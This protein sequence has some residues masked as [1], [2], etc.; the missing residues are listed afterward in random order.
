M[1]H[2]RGVLLVYNV[3]LYAA[4]IRVAR[5]AGVYPGV[6]GHGLLDH[7]ATRRLGPL[8]RYEA[9]AASR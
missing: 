4:R 5:L 3:H 6:A 1:M 2:R 9:D 8:L 7:Q